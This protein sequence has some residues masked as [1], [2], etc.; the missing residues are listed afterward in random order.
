MKNAPFIYRV[1]E[2]GESGLVAYN[3]NRV[4]VVDSQVINDQHH[5]MDAHVA[6]HAHVLA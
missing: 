2:S 1:Q 3:N 6:K 4:V 5:L